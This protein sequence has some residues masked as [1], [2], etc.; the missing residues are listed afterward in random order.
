MDV[1]TEMTGMNEIKMFL[2]LNIIIQERI[3][4]PYDRESQVLLQTLHRVSN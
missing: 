1:D 2:W 3:L 4:R